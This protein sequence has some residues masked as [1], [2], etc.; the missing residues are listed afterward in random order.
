M[1]CSVSLVG[2][3][4]VSTGLSGSGKSTLMHDCCCRAVIEHG[5][6]EAQ[7]QRRLIQ[8]FSVT[9]EIEAI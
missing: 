4:S 5:K 2:R 9:E 8:L 3:L 6:D 1:S 7:R